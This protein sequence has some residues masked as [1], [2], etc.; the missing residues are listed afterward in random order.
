LN[1][2]IDIARIGD[3][4]HMIV[5]DN[6]TDLDALREDLQFEMIALHGEVKELDVSW[7]FT[8]IINRLLA[9]EGPALLL[10]PRIKKQIERL[11]KLKGDFEQNARQQPAAA[12]AQVAQSLHVAEFPVTKDGK[13]VKQCKTQR[14]RQHPPDIA[15]DEVLPSWGEC[16]RYS[17]SMDQQH[18]NS[19][20]AMARNIYDTILHS[21]NPK[22]CCI[23]DLHKSLVTS[24]GISKHQGC[25]IETRFLLG[26]D[27]VQ[28]K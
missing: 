22:R 18:Y 20:V 11:K 7:D 21:Q 6:S 14:S 28:Q 1:F 24:A 5:D 10:V 26:S 3:M 19:L 4:S 13:P 12:L 16:K 23:C 9:D 25:C 15:I 8:P 27:R 2:E 17:R